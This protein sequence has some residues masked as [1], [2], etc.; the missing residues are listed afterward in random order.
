MRPRRFSLSSVGLL[1]VSSW[2]GGCAL[3]AEGELPEVEI[4]QHDV[5]IPAAPVDASGSEASLAVV[6]RQTPTRL[7]LKGASFSRVQILG[8]VIA[9]T[10]GV[11]DLRFLHRLRVLATSPEEQA[12]GR[13]PLEVVRYQRSTGATAAAMLSLPSEPPA[14]VT[15][16][17]RGSDLVF[18]LEITGQLPS[19]AWTADV[20]LRF[21]A[22]ITY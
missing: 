18:T 21:A 9:A 5:A 10:S 19:V 3:S 8:L 14:D 16:L 7:G 22:T 11:N 12:M 17:W 20:G 2:L 6:F 13:A 4:T 15:E 1:A